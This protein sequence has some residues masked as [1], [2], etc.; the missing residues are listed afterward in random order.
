MEICDNVNLIIKDNMKLY[1]DSFEKLEEFLK[2]N[3]KLNDDFNE[4]I[5]YLRT[6]PELIKYVYRI[7]SIYAKEFPGEKLIIE[8]ITLFDDPVLSVDVKTSCSGF[9]A[10]NK[11][12]LVDSSF[13]TDS[14][15]LENILLDVRFK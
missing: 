5:S 8:V 11:M 4:V 15:S 1:N 9:D 6:N 14:F 12:D 2:E 13:Y 10:A 7:P 3:F